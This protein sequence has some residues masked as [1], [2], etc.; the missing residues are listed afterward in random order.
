MAHEAIHMP[1]PAPHIS[2]ARDEEQTN[3]RACHPIAV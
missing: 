1:R 2:A 3:G